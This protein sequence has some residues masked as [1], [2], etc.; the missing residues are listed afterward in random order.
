MKD[1]IA[2]IQSYL[3]GDKRGF[4]ILYVLS[5][6][7]IG[8][9]CYLV[10][11]EIYWLLLMPLFLVILYLYFFSLDKVILLITMVTPLAINFTQFEFN[12]GISVPSEPL[13]F[14]VLLMFIIKL[15]YTND[16]DRKIWSHPMTI[17]I[18]LQLFWMLVTSI[19][20][21]LPLVSFKHLLARLWFV[22]PFYFL[23]VHLFRK[24]L[25]INLFVWCYTLPLLIVIGYTIYNHSLWG[26]DERAGH[27]VM[28][29]FYN[30]HTAY[31]MT[32]ALFIPM[33]FGFLLNRSLSNSTRFFSFLILA[34]LL[35]ALV[36][37]YSRAAWL[38]LAFA[39]L[40]FLIV[41]FKIKFK[42]ILSGVI[43]FGIFF[44]I[45]SFEILD[46][47]EKNQQG[48]SA[49]YVEHL[50][51]ISNISTDNSNL[52]R[53]N[54][55]QSA[56]R[57]YE[58]RP[59]FGY[60]PGTYQF[61]YAPFQRSEEKTLIS[62]NAGDKGNAHSEYIGPLA[63]QGL[64]GM[65]LVIALVVAM[66]IIAMRVYR[67]S[68]NP[69]VRNVSLSLML[70]LMTYFLHGTMNNFLDTDKASV[71]VWGFIAAIV[72]LDLYAKEK[73]IKG[74]EKEESE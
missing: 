21:D 57:M 63:E 33:F 42:W 40:V 39:F 32:L 20:S 16:F 6:L 67:N 4:T 10:Y 58:D 56:L 7:F 69:T 17:I 27:W 38:S 3:F 5:A 60:G 24:Q 12:V 34:V 48:P 53:I 68:A 45:F 72:A 70:S 25:N 28:E 18:G 44:Y 15:F 73:S 41:I 30:D 36:L 61:E 22:V 47:L 46:R 8:L 65:L 51:S 11:R 50:R 26:F 55:W 35:V 49:N 59:V 14:G 31:G 54:R 9:N 37:S 66:V 74:S 62:T 23:G 1:K 13:M 43:V 52:E 19:T 64:P 71:P 2:L 29:P